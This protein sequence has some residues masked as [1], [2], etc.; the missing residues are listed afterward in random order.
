LQPIKNFKT[1]RC[2]T[3]NFNSRKA[4]NTF[5]LRNKNFRNNIV[6]SDKDVPINRK[7]F[8]NVKKIILRRCGKYD[9]GL[10]SKI[11]RNTRL[12]DKTLKS[13]INCSSLN[14][15]FISDTKYKSSG[16]VYG[17]QNLIQNYKN[18]SR[19]K[20]TVSKFKDLYRITNSNINQNY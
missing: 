6:I 4:K 14:Y 15:N 11:I 2:Q 8:E 12:N 19:K 1:T 7:P 17:I 13:L 3:A 16:R 20:Q 9:R 5:N 10:P 18:I